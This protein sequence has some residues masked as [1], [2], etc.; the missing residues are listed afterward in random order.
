MRE[1]LLQAMRGRFPNH[2]PVKMNRGVSSHPRRTRQHPE[3][4]AIT[5]IST[6]TKQ[7]SQDRPADRLRDPVPSTH[8]LVKRAKT[9][10]S[11]ISGTIESLVL[12]RVMA[13]TKIHGWSL[14]IQ[15][16]TRMVSI[17][18]QEYIKTPSTKTQVFRK[19]K[20]LK[21]NI[22]ILNFKL[23]TDKI[24]KSPTCNFLYVK[25]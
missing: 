19:E 21:F 23:L 4:E 1:V 10:S 18:F 3:E 17:S 20:V 14:V 22:W 7:E 13:S 6:L 12:R 5:I 2:Q 11:M 8:R 25:P 9:L 16:L 15:Q 24:H